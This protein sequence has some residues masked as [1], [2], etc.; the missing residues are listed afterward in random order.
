MESLGRL[1]LSFSNS[2]GLGLLQVLLPFRLVTGSTCSVL[3]VDLL[4]L[5]KLFLVLR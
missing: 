2:I 5:S 1:S 4:V 3:F